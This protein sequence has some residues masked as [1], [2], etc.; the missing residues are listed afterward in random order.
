[1]WS[2]GTQDAW[3]T[4]LA[5]HLTDAT[6]V[7]I[8]LIKSISPNAV[9]FIQANADNTIS[10]LDA[11]TFR[12]AIGADGAYIKNQNA[13][14]QSSSNFWISGNGT[15]DGVIKSNGGIETVLGSPLLSFGASKFMFQQ[16]TSTHTR[17]YYT[18]S[19]GSTYGNLEFYRA[20]STG[21]PSIVLALHSSGNVGVGV[22]PNTGAILQAKGYVD[23]WNSANTLMRLNNNGF[24]SSIESFVGG[25]YASLLLNPNAGNVGVGTSN[26]VSKVH[27]NYSGV[28]N[29]FVLV[30][31]NNGGTYFGHNADNRGVIAGYLNTDIVFGFNQSTTFV[32]TSRMVAST[33]H[34]GLGTVNPNVRLEVADDIRIN[35][36]GGISGGDGYGY[37]LSNLE[38]GNYFKLRYF[39]SNAVYSNIIT[40]TY[41]G[42]VGIGTNPLEKFHVYGN[43]LFGTASSIGVPYA[44]QI[45]TNGSSPIANRLAFGTDGTGW[46]MAISKNQGGTITDL[47]VI[48]DNGRVS[49]GTTIIGSKLF[50]V[51]GG[52]R[53]NDVISGLVYANSTGEFQAAGQSDVMTVL[54]DSAYIKNQ[55]SYDQVASFRIN[56]TGVFA[57]SSPIRL[58][59]AG[60]QDIHSNNGGIVRFIN[61]EYSYANLEIHQTGRLVVRT[62]I[63]VNTLANTSALD[64]IYP[65]TTASLDYNSYAIANFRG[66]GHVQLAI[67]SEI[68]GSYNGHGMV[69]QSKH[70]TSNGSAY[71]I[72]L[73]PLGGSIG[74]GTLRPA[75]FTKLHLSG[76]SSGSTGVGYGTNRVLL[77]SNTDI[78]YGMHLGVAGSGNSWI[79]SGRADSTTVYDLCFQHEGGKVIIGGINS[80]GSSAL[81]VQGDIYG[82][83]LWGSTVLVKAVS[84]VL[85][86]AESA[87]LS[88][89]IGDYYIK[90]QFS[91]AQ[92]GSYWINGNAVV[93]HY[94]QDARFVVSGTHTDSTFMLFSIGNGTATGTSS[95]SMWASEPGLTYEGCGIGSNIN[96]SPYLGRRETAQPQSYVRFHGGN[97][98]FSTSS[99]QNTNPSASTMNLN[100]TGGLTISNTNSSITLYISGLGNLY[101]G[102]GG[103]DS[104][105]WIDAVSTNLNLYGSTIVAKTNLQLDAGLKAGGS[106]GTSGYILSSTGSGVQWIAPSS[107]ALTNTYIGVGNGS[108]ILSGSGNLTWSSVQIHINGGTGTFNL[109]KGGADNEYWVDAASTNLNLYGS[110]VVAKANLQLDAGL[111][112]GGSYGTSG[113]ILS[114]TGSGVQ[115]IAPT[116]SSVGT[117]D[118]VLALGSTS[119]GKSITINSSSD[120]FLFNTYGGAFRGGIAMDGSLYIYSSGVDLQ[121]VADFNLNLLG[122]TV[123]VGYSGTSYIMMLHGM[124]FNFNEESLY[125]GGATWGSGNN[126]GAP[127]TGDVIAFR[128]D[129]T[130][131][132]PLKVKTV[133]ANIGGTNYDVMYRVNGN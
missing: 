67:N 14:A 109:G 19:D 110:T 23:V 58:D 85:Y 56:G 76:L 25:A 40:A 50:Q 43:A 46:G 97:I 121:V 128:Y 26:P 51:N 124:P 28:A 82:S 90:N 3:T 64:L 111:K 126:Q 11:A 31:H 115:W 113:Y 106:Y 105:Y 16:E 89:L 69:F 33:G 42:N 72:L 59:N 92:A 100:T 49:L 39:A 35:Y 95:I 17:A 133:V 120:Y 61:S 4:L 108:N 60:N 20:T 93:G 75:A 15:V 7:G 81:Q 55:I 38:S 54:G 117:L 45:L 34:F 104:D 84:G 78:A 125:Q 118:Q 74:I 103:A 44:F 86:R 27:V 24:N 37:Q 70:S 101:I 119:Y 62:S 53:Q 127:Q 99:S 1:M 2:N 123:T 18:G 8:N 52:I 129:G 130:K 87:D 132:V 30:G 63:G 116:S 9:T 57:H 13:S 12:T 88:G 21:S 10:W 122:D 47:I 68:T 79:Q 65:N 80:S 66:S 36:A 73:N 98:Y 77:I 107:A 112:A 41:T 32:E 29:T 48:S 114:S 22:V 131:F 6:A 83:T 102:K 96:Q 5:S 94:Q 71:D 91:N